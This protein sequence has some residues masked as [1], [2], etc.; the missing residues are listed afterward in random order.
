MSVWKNIIK[1]FIEKAWPIIIKWIEDNLMEIIKWV[2]E[3]IKEFFESKQ[4][5]ENERYEENINKAQEK[6]DNAE[7]D[8]EKRVWQETIDMLKKMYEESKAENE[9]LKQE[10]EKYKQQATNDVKKEVR[11]VKVDDIFDMNGNNVVPKSNTP[12][13]S[14]PKISSDIFKLLK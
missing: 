8:D 9:I 10:M 11:K 6:Y 14:L 3:H 5:K 13:I 4:N 12:A 2:I 1:W 7:N